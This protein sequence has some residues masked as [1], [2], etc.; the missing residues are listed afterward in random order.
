MGLSQQPRRGVLKTVAT[1]PFNIVRGGVALVVGGGGDGLM[2]PRTPHTPAGDGLADQWIDF[3][4]EQAERDGAV[5]GQQAREVID[6]SQ[7]NEG[8]RGDSAAS[9]AAV[10]H[11]SRVFEG[12]SAHVGASNSGPPASYAA[13]TPLQVLSRTEHQQVP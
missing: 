12:Q 9:S 5:T 10:T 8:E 4:I 13:L 1:M 6:N 7:T 3:L 2:S 11:A